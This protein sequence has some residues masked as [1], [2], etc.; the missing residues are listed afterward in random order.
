MSIAIVITMHL[1]MSIL[2]IR[3]KRI[4]T[5]KESSITRKARSHKL[6]AATR[7]AGWIGSTSQI[8]CS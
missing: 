1:S 2:L 3:V 6:R 4:I 5:C 7:K 8:S